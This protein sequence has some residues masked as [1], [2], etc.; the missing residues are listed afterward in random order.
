MS[1]LHAHFSD[2]LAMHAIFD[3]DPAG[4]PDAVTPLQLT[5]GYIL[6]QGEVAGLKAGQGRT[7][8]RGFYPEHIELSVTDARDRNWDFAGTPLTTFPWQAWP[9]TVGHNVLARWQCRGQ[10]GY[11][12]V[13]DFI[14]LHALTEIYSRG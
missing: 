5:H 4:G 14:G 3:F 9:G 8:R 1:W 7:E 12:E 13:M 11:G 6:D 2:D 10:T